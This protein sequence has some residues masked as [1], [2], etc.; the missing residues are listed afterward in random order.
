MNVVP[1]YS[2]LQ[3]QGLTQAI[4]DNQSRISTF[5]E[6]S[7]QTNINHE[8]GI[9]GLENNLNFD[10]LKWHQK[11]IIDGQASVFISTFDKLFEN[12]SDRYINASSKYSEDIVNLQD[13]NSYMHARGVQYSVTVKNFSNK[14]ENYI[15]VSGSYSRYNHKYDGE[16]TNYLAEIPNFMQQIRVS[17]MP[18]KNFTI[19]TDYTTY[20]KSHFAK[21]NNSLKRI[22]DSGVSINN[23]ALNNDYMFP[24]A[25]NLDLLLQYR[26]SSNF[27]VYLKV[28]NLSE[29]E[30]MG[31]SNIVNQNDNLFYVP[32]SHAMSWIGLNYT[33]D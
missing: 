10:V 5:R 33:L 6:F 21:L 32:Q 17:Y 14:P 13:Q 16:T 15:T 19:I 11:W 4:V 20:G 30:M 28:S 27:Q 8:I 2:Y 29:Q 7:L 26:F 1:A 12:K 9:R 18:T 22:F 31:L 23:L 24:R 25:S 3:N